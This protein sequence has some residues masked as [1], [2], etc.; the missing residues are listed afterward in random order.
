MAGW[1]WHSKMEDLFWNLE[2]WT[3][4]NEK[5]YEDFEKIVKKDGW[6]EEF[7]QEVDKQWAKIL[8]SFWTGLDAKIQIA[9]DEFDPTNPEKRKWTMKPNV[10]EAY[11][12]LW[13]LKKWGLHPSKTPA[14]DTPEQWAWSGRVWLYKEMK[15][16]AEQEATL[17]KKYQEMLKVI[18]NTQD[19]SYNTKQAAKEVIKQLFAECKTVEEFE[20]R[21]GTS[22]STMDKIDGI[23]DVIKNAVSTVKEIPWLP[24]KALF[25]LYKKCW[26]AKEQLNWMWKEA[27]KAGDTT[28]NEFVEWSKEQWQKISDITKTILLFGEDYFKQFLNYL[29]WINEWIE[30]ALITAW[31][32]CWNQWNK[33]VSLCWE[34]KD[35]VLNFWKQLVEK[36]QLE[37][38]AFLDSAK[39]DWDKVKSFCKDLIEKWKIKFGEFVDWC[40]WMAQKGKD[41]LMSIV[42]S[43]AA[44]WNKF[45]DWC[46]DNWEAAKNTFKE[47]ARSLLEKGKMTLNAFIDWCKGAWETVKDA[48]CSILV[49]LVK[50]WK[51]SL[52]V[53]CGA[54]LVVVGSVVL[55]WELM[56]KA[57]KEI[58]KWGKELA[59]FVS[60]LALNMWEKA[61]D[62]Y[63]SASEFVHSMLQKCKEWGIA[64]AEFVKDF[65]KSTWE[66][67]KK[68]GI[69]AKDFIT[70]TYEAVKTSLKGKWNE[71][72][73]FFRKLWMN[74][75]EVVTTL[76]EKAKWTW[77]NC[78][79]FVAG[80]VEKWWLNFKSAMSLLLD[81]CRMAIDSVWRAF[82]KWKKYVEQ[83][84]NYVKE[85]GLIT[86]QNIRKWCEN[87]AEDIKLFFRTAIDKCKATWNDVKEWC[88]WRIQDI[89]NVLHEIYWATKEWVK[90][91]INLMKEWGM[92]VLDAGKLIIGL[93]IGAVALVILGL[94][95]FW[96]KLADVAKMCVDSLV[97]TWK[98]AVGKICDFLSEAYGKSKEMLIKIWQYVA[99]WIQSAAEWVRDWIY[100]RTRDAKKAYEAMRNFIHDW[101]RDVAKWLYQRGVDLVDVCRTI[102]N[103]FWAS[104]RTAYE[105]LK[106]F[107]RE[108]QIGTWELLKAAWEWVL[109]L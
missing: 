11:M 43:S 7:E 86:I 107:A 58:Y 9:T 5:E 35:S 17:D 49:W 78:V 30:E 51:F 62:A 27:I 97:R 102:K 72:A 26:V 38:R 92:A 74:I 50:A 105:W 65:V 64:T 6:R 24:K 71:V 57:W 2:W 85:K 33:L 63:K 66:K 39:N 76:Y 108:C 54:L 109:D 52:D 68:F 21:V 10:R 99:E 69:T 48:A 98:Y 61:K 42:E 90:K 106:A 13:K 31:E 25:E 73:N 83:F 70:A 12:V 44:M 36:W 67:M 15:D 88:N 4:D 89:K 45:A 20:K 104:L 100:Q 32:Y 55:L 101:V 84:I 60:S 96:E 103:A 28:I 56:V 47:V 81:K 8:Q 41:I 1:N 87:R 94:K 37:W 91:L 59:N 3:I 82:M 75:T 95:E 16:A 80:A 18:D 46:K 23:K 53:V 34:V 40:K 22:L 77:N 93:G 19:W 14:W 79:D 29:E